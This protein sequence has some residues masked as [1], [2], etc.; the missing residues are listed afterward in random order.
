MDNNK[1][2]DS[3]IVE[4]FKLDS[5]KITDELTAKDIPDWDSMNYLL[6]ISEIEKQFNITFSMEEVL[7]AQSLGDIR[8]MLKKRII[9]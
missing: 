7:N 3:I 6:F 2:F 4:I 9:K 1:K 8:E 5:S